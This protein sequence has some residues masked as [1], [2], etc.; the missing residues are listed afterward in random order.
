MNYTY[1]D[2]IESYTDYKRLSDKN[3]HFILY[4]IYR[5]LSFP[6]TWLFLKLKFSANSITLITI[7]I[8]VALPFLLISE[9]VKLKFVAGVLMFFY[10]LLD[11][12]DG[13]VARVTNTTKKVGLFFDAFSGLLFWGLVFPFVGIGAS[14]NNIYF[15]EIIYLLPHFGFYIV[16]LFFM[17]RLLSQQCKAMSVNFEEDDNQPSSSIYLF[18]KSFFDLIP[19]LYLVALYSLAVDIFLS[20]FLMY[21]LSV[22]IYIIYNSYHILK[23]E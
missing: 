17:A 14:E 21:S 16:I 13:N 22:L 5:P 11:C 10:L 12:V 7:L 9:T 4:H 6:V 8:S 1:K 15:K 3:S 23:N 18:L 19:I 20:L 2:I